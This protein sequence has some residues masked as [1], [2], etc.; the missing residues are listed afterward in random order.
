MQEDSDNTQVNVEI[1]NESLTTLELTRTQSPDAVSKQLLSLSPLFSEMNREQQYR[2]ILLQAHSYTLSGDFNEAVNL[3]TP[4]LLKPF[5][6]DLIKY[7]TRTMYLLANTYSHFNYYVESLRTLHQLLPLLADVDDIE[8]EVYGYTLAVE[9]FGQMDLNDEALKYAKNLYSKFDTIKLPRHQCFTSYSYAESIDGVYGKDEGKLLEIKSLYSS[10]LNFCKS[11]NEEMIMAASLL[12]Q[13]KMLFFLGHFKEARHEV[14]QAIELS[15]SIP[16]LLD[17]ADALILLSEIDRVENR[18]DLALAHTEKAL[19]IALIVND[20]GVL[21]KVYKSLSEINESLGRTSKALEYLKLFQKNHT[22]ILGET[23]NKIIAFETTKLDYL[24]KERQI[25]YLNKDRE[26]YT[27]KAELTESQR[28]NERMMFLLICGSLVILT[29]FAIS[30][31]LQKRKYKRLAQFDVLTGIYNRG[32]GQDRA[33]N[34][35]VKD[36]ISDT[37]FSVILFDLDHFKNIN[38][39]YGHAMGDW[40]LKKVC[41]VVSKECRSGDIFTRF[42]GEEFALF[43]S[44]TGKDTA[45]EVA[46]KCRLQVLAIETRYSGH[47]FTVSASFGVTTSNAEDLSLD[48]ILQRADIAM[49]QSKKQGR[50]R[51]TVYTQEMNDN[52]D[53]NPS[54]LGLS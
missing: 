39:N 11:A 6:S 30:M 34:R 40:V 46:E 22:K 26:L 14:L 25:R 33:E 3:L 52:R 45:K 16:Y 38:D 4:Q 27:A 37:D 35:F 19:E 9:L 32:T 41:E 1:L 36:S 2:F 49:Y 44:N 23:Q 24:E 20:E 18:D 10:A 48:P 51:V 47:E 12:G 8:S 13:A 31:T 28:N 29:M 53:K 5:D 42:G 50:D 21:A 43:M 15:E 7:K 17:V 54:E